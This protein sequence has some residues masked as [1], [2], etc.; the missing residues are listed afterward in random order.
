[1]PLLTLLGMPATMASL[2]GLQTVA[3][4]TGSIPGFGSCA[5]NINSG[6]TQ[7]AADV[8]PDCHVMIGGSA[9]VEGYVNNPERCTPLLAGEDETPTKGECTKKNLGSL[10]CTAGQPMRMVP[11]QKNWGSTCNPIS[12]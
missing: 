1:M 5:F 12:P 11:P 3:E 7:L 6:S 4:I 8:M 9:V 10:N 2:F